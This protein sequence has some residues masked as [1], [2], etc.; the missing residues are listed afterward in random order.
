M[1]VSFISHHSLILKIVIQ[2]TNQIFQSNCQSF[3][4]F[5]V[6]K[7]VSIYHVSKLLG[8]AD[9]KTPQIYSHLRR[10]DLRNSLNMLSN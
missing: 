7:S 2:K 9:L 4:L 10:D 3:A 8:N 1:V 6:Q 5:L